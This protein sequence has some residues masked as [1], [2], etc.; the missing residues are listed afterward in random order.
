MKAAPCQVLPENSRTK[1]ATPATK[2]VAAFR[3][4][5]LPSP[6]WAGKLTPW[7]RV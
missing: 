7:R 2:V 3:V 6:F 4:T 5:A 1:S